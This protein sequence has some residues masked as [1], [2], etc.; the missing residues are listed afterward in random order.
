MNTYQRLAE[1]AEQQN[2]VVS[3]DQ[4]RSIGLTDHR[5]TS[6]VQGGYLTRPASGALQIAGCPPSWHQQVMVAVA[7]A[8]DAALASHQTAAFLWELIGFRPDEIEVVMPRWD[9]SQKQS[10]KVHESKDLLPQDFDR[11]EG[12]PVTTAV[13]TIV[14]LG[15]TARWLVEGA[16]ER[17]IRLGLFTLGDVGAFVRRVG[18]RGRRGVGVIR[19]LLE[20][21]LRWDRA[22]ESEL[23][24]LFRN[25]WSHPGRPEPAAQHVIVDG[26]GRFVCRADF[27]FPDARLRIELDSEAYHMDRPTFRK[28]RSVQNRTELL[29]WRTLRYT[30][31]DLTSRPAAV[32]AEVAD[33]LGISPHPAPVLASI[34]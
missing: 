21:R 19:P 28:D 29:G 32:V 8:G 4:A 26:T 34:R 30:W 13:R 25:V 22:T 9:R 17:G 3:L 10:F 20:Q 24:D 12:I 1:V 16:L 27:A 2:G 15:A 31:W 11:V 23:E 33:A 18:R 14:D 7:A 6:L 5:I